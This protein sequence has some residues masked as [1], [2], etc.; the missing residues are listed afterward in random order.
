[1]KSGMTGT[2]RA[3]PHWNHIDGSD[4]YKSYPG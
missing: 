1:M 2:I 4:N 3:S